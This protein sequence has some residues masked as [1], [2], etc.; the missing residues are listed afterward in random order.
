MSRRF[1]QKRT[2]TFLADLCGNHTCLCWHDD[3]FGEAA[4][5]NRGCME[6]MIIISEEEGHQ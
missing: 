2:R 5:G 4:R 6:T 1:L 3:F